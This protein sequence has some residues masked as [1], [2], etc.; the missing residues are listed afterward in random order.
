MRLITYVRSDRDKMNGLDNIHRRAP[1]S[2][3]TDQK[4]YVNV[5]RPLRQIISVEGV[6]NEN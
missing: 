6:N 5:Q 3:V 2:V 4:C 1:Y